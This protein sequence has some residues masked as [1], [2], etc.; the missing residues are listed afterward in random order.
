MPAVP[1]RPGPKADPWASVLLILAGLAALAQLVLPWRSAQAELASNWPGPEAGPAGQAIGVSGW[2]FYLALHDL[3]TPTFELVLGRWIVL[4]TAGAGLALLLLGLLTLLPMD[5]RP[6]GTVALLVSGFCVLGS[7]V[8][9]ARARTFFG[10]GLNGLF[11]QA[12]PGFYLLLAAGLIGLA[13]AFK[14]LGSR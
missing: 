1:V 2:D 10:V 12:Q 7:V 3:A 6:F 13:G 9:L 8:L 11:D 14:A 4:G 5:H